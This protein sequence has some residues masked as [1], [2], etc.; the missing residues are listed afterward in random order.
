MKTDSA[1]ITVDDTAGSGGV[2]IETP[3]GMKITL[4]AGG[5]TIDDGQGATIELSGPR[6]SINDD[7]L[8]I[9]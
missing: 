1:T 3:D 2:T 7:A 9:T 6:V 4:D 8:E 5:I